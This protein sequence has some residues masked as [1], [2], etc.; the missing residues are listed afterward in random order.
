MA[1][2][3]NFASAV[4]HRTAEF[5]D[6]GVRWQRALWNTGLLLCL[7]ELIEASDAVT[8]GALSTAAVKWLADNAKGRVASDPGVGSD[9]ERRAILALL[10]RDL[11]S[12]GANYLELKQWIDA[13]EAAYLPRWGEAVSSEENRPSREETA[14]ALAAH[15]LDLRFSPSALTSWLQAMKGEGGSELF[16]AA[17]ELAKRAPSTY[18]VMLLFAKPPPKRI[19]RPS[20]WRE[21]RD[22]S[23]WLAEHGFQ[24]MRQHGG[25]LLDLVDRDPY[26]AARQAAD[27]VDRVLARVSVGTRETVSVMR[28]AFIPGL[29]G[30]IDLRR[31]RRVEIR[32]LE[33]EQRLLHLERTGPVDD[34]LELVSH[35]NTAP[36]PV[37]VTGG[38]S[39]IESLLSG[40]GD[41]DK[42]VTAERLGYLVACSWPRAELTTLAWA[43]QGESPDD[44]LGKT[45][46]ACSTNRQRSEAL[47]AT[48]GGEEGLAMGGARDQLAQ[49]RVEKLMRSPRQSLL[50]IQ[51]EAAASLR[52]LYRQ[53]NLV[54]HGGQVA[55][56]AL[57]A[58]LRTVAPIVGAGLDRIAH[59]SLTRGERP[60]DLAARAR[61]QIERAGSDGGPDLPALLE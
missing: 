45:L 18:E 3:N 46:L 2:A 61:M 10:E 57:S 25:L 38:W 60:L 15:L 16:A 42:V 51:R 9:V 24:T 19:A 5:V 54:V 6:P 47:L 28:H 48:L 23:S 44:R 56:E 17:D 26:S 30:Q 29:S 4:L 33:R 13:I 50:A 39:A 53:R 37:A 43:R 14:R 32:A 22:V 40:P 21:A 7:K 59:A 52:R 31:V 8:T 58:T 27:V 55:G 20:Q 11:S 34:A 12:G 1:G 35:L 36:P 49:K 41:T